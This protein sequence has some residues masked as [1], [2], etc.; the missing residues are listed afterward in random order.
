MVMT[1]GRIVDRI[2][3]CWVEEADRAEARKC[4]IPE[5]AEIRICD[6]LGEV[7][8]QKHFESLFKTLQSRFEAIRM[9]GVPTISWIVHV[10][11]DEAT[12]DGVI[13]NEI[14]G[15]IHALGACLNVDMYF[16]AGEKC[17]AT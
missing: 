7:V 11:R 10:G 3:D 13:S 5:V 6:S 2:D 15:K 16:D 4:A 17:G 12:P 9:L 14:L 8:V 1:W